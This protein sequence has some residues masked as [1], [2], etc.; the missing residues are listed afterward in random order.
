MAGSTPYGRSAYQVPVEDLDDANDYP[1]PSVLGMGE[2]EERILAAND[3]LADL[4]ATH[5]HLA[6]AAANAEADWK[7]H[8]DRVIVR[9]H[10]STERTAA[11]TR[12]AIARAEMDPETGQAG[13]ELYRTYK[14]TTYAMESSAR[15]M[16]AI[17]ARLNSLQTISAN[18]RSVAT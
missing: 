13:D 8:R 3:E 1:L 5:T 17:E 7:A 12:E 4:T 6:D 16:R 10:H 14:V 2:V 18:L 15:A 9:L 11:D